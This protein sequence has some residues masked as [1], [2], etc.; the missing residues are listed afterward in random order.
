MTGVAAVAFY[1]SNSSVA[2][3]PTIALENLTSLVAAE[4]ASPA[5]KVSKISTVPT[6]TVIFEISNDYRFVLISVL[7]NVFVYFMC[8]GVSGSTRSS[9]FSQ[10]KM[11]EHFGE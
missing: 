5:D 3:E 11:D 8:M 4:P 1:A 10:E 9:E 2:R 7:V 6:S